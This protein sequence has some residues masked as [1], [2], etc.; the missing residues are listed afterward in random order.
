MLVSYNW[1]KDF[2]NMDGV[3]PY[4]LAEKLTNIVVNNKQIILFMLIKIITTLIYF[5]IWGFIVHAVSNQH[6]WGRCYFYGIT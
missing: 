3:D 5:S 2:L 1:L 4:A 6:L